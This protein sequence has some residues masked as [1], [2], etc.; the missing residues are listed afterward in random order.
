MLICKP[1]SHPEKHLD[2]FTHNIVLQ[3]AVDSASNT[4][5]KDNYYSMAT[6][7]FLQHG[8]YLLVYGLEI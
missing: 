3:P 1:R 5:E 6:G 2:A 4:S 7:H 8:I